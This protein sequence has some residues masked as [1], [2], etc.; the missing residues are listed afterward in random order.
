MLRTSCSAPDRGYAE[1]RVLTCGG[2]F[3]SAGV[4]GVCTVLQVVEG[5]TNR[6]GAANERP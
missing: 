3:M 6:W 4:G 5:T 2:V 1:C